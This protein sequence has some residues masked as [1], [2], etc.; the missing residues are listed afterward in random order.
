MK[1]LLI[2]MAALAS[3][4]LML[5]FRVNISRYMADLAAL[6]AAGTVLSVFGGAGILLE[7]YFM[8]EKP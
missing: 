6:L 8:E 7:L 5:L 3:G 4:L 1:R 2:W